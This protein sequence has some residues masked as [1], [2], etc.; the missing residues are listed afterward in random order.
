MTLERMRNGSTP[1]SIMRVMAPAAS[2]VWIVERTRCPV[3]DA[4]IAMSS[5]LLV[6]NLADHD[7]VRVLPE[8]GAQRAG[9]READLGL[10]VDL[11]DPVDLVLDRI[12]GRQDVEVRRG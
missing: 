8:E 10:H 11:V 7:D 6:A 9:E 2:F 5:G 4:L 12:L 1:M 3:R